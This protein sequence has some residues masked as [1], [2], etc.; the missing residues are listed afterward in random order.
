MNMPSSQHWRIHIQAWY[1]NSTPKANTLSKFCI[2]QC[3]NTLE[4]WS[5]YKSE[6]HRP[7]CY[8]DDNVHRA[9]IYVLWNMLGGQGG[10]IILRKAIWWL[11]GSRYI[12]YHIKSKKT[13]TDQY[14]TKFCSKLIYVL[15]SFIFWGFSLLVGCWQAVTKKVK[16]CSQKKLK[17]KVRS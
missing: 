16:S 6:I 10:E 17:A 11:L 2:W 12:L 1:P 9:F 7:N 8:K 14:K 13:F 15:P 3:I 5:V 4:S